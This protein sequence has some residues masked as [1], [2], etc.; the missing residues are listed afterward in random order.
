MT[1]VTIHAYGLASGCSGG[2]RRNS[3]LLFYTSLPWYK[4]S[5]PDRTTDNSFDNTLSSKPDVAEVR[6]K[7][8]PLRAICS[9][10]LF[11]MDVIAIAIRSL[12]R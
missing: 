12:W 6:L 2:R 11:L 7:K 5:V 4:M 10:R 8:K 3:Y 1:L 9:K